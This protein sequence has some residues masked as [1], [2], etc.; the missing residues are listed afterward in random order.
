VIRRRSARLLPPELVGV[1][2]GADRHTEFISDDG[3][4]ALIPA[5]VGELGL[6]RGTCRRDFLHLMLAQQGERGE[7]IV[8]ERQLRLP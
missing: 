7:E 4:A 1:S 8:V 2:L 5:E 6:I 3:L